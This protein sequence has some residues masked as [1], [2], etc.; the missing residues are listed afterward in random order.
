MADTHV[1][2]SIQENLGILLDNRYI[3]TSLLDEIEPQVATNFIDKYTATL[4]SQGHIKSRGQQIP[5]MS[6]FPQQEIQSD[7]YIVVSADSGEQTVSS[8]GTIDATYGYRD[9]GFH[10]ETLPIS[11]IESGNTVVFTAPVP[12]GDVE[13]I[14]GLSLSHNAI[15]TDGNLIKVKLPDSL[16]K[17][18]S[19]GQ[20]FEVSYEAT[21][22]TPVAGVSRGYSMDESVRILVLAKNMDTL[23]CIDALMKAIIVL[24]RNSDSE[25]K[26]YTLGKLHFDPISAMEEQIPSLPN[27]TFGRTYLLT[28]QVNYNWDQ[29]NLVKLKHIILEAN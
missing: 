18:V 23:R 10:R 22:T 8:L 5:V 12:V 26:V 28:Y 24:I 7:A 15:T 25:Q 9:K 19:V 17:L 16:L 13:K 4:D 2:K 3:I 11:S 14:L 21:N 6:S 29:D 1:R 27:I 20:N